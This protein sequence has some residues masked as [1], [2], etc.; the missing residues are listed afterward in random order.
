MI[1]MQAAFEEAMRAYNADEVP[2][3]AVLLLDDQIIARG[4]NQTEA[5]RDA[6]RHAE[7]VCIQQ[8]MELRGDFRL[9]SA[10]L[11]TTLEPCIMCAGAII[12]SRIRKVVY[13]CPDLRHGACGSLLNVFEKKHPIHQVE[14][15]WLDFQSQS[16]NLLKKFFREKR[17]EKK[18]RR[19]LQSPKKETV[20]HRKRDCPLC[21]E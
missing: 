21:N 14:V 20:T 2:V 13:G 6:T 15:E 12:L 10:V 5:S 1:A 3:G 19:T 16:A 7:M 18:I 8:A 4:H 9:D 11:Y 17:H